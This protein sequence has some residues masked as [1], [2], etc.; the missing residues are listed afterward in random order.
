MTTNHATQPLII[1][2]SGN[3][4]TY[5]KGRLLPEFSLAF[6]IKKALV[7]RIIATTDLLLN[8]L[9]DKERKAND[10]IESVTSTTFATTRRFHMFIGNAT[11]KSGITN[12][13]VGHSLLEAVYGSV[14]PTSEHRK[15]LLDNDGIYMVTYAYNFLT[16]NRYSP[17]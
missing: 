8:S 3:R 7:A 11:K 10:F 9:H 14:V 1:Y 13:M 15:I 12:E 17:I 4:D 2:S 16:G 6:K 5:E